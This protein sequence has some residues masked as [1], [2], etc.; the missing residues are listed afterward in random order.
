MGLI[1]PVIDAG[2]KHVAGLFGG[3]I[4][5]AGRIP[6]EGLQQYLYS[7]DH[8]KQVAKQSKVDVELQNHPLYDGLDERL[9]KLRERKPGAP[10]PFIVGQ[11][12]YGKFLDVMSECMRAQMARRA[13]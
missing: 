13:E 8:F 10:H 4:L 7:I 2:K 3:T 5:L 11:G 1:F 6:D 12:N 9:A